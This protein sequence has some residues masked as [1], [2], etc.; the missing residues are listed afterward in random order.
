MVRNLLLF[1]E[2]QQII[3][4]EQKTKILVPTFHLLFIR[5]KPWKNFLEIMVNFN[6]FWL[7][8]S[9]FY[10][11]NFV[12]FVFISWVNRIEE[13]FESFVES[14][15]FIFFWAFDYINLVKGVIKL[16]GFWKALNLKWLS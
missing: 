16:N 10:H 3:F 6:H 8:T 13:E 15:N 11:L 2:P 14:L 4:F 9:F 12:S 7:K 1:L 5:H